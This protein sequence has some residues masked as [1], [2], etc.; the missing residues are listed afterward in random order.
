MCYPVASCSSSSR[1]STLAAAAKVM[2]KPETGGARE[3]TPVG[4][5]QQQA[6]QAK[7][8]YLATVLGGT[9]AAIGFRKRPYCLHS[10][11]HSCLL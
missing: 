3:Q 11:G 6:P 1:S 2:R 5:A 8:P 4:S 9:S 10:Y 7:Q